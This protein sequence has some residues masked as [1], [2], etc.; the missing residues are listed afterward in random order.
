[1][2]MPNHLR[3][4]LRKLMLMHVQSNIMSPVRPAGGGPGSGAAGLYS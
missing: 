4:T 2:R 3:M 1:M